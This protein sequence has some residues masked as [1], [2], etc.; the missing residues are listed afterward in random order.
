MIDGNG[1]AGEKDDNWFEIWYLVNRNKGEMCE[2]SH[3]GVWLIDQRFYETLSGIL[4][5]A[6]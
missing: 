3:I 1:K 4:F 2:F 5:S 6:C